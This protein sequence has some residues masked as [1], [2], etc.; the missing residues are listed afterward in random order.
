MSQI[1]NNYSE[2]RDFLRIKITAPLPCEIKYDSTVISGICTDLSGGGMQIS[3]AT[4]IPL[5]QEASVSLRSEFGHA[6]HLHALI[7]LV[8]KS[9]EGGNWLLGFEI[10]ELLD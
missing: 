1:N 6:P 5:E 2:K 9:R 3:S 4:D 8:R 10:Q 7:K